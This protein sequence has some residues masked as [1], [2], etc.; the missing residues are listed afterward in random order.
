MTTYSEAVEQTI[1]AG[2]QIHQIVNGT[3][4]TEVTV[5]DGSKVPSI[6]KALLD[7]FYFKDPIAWQVGQTENVFNQ[8][9]QF[10]D[11]SWWYAPSATASNPISMG[12]TPV[13]DPLWKVYDFDAIGRLEPR[14]DEALRRSYAEAGYNVIGTFQDGF[15]YINTNDVGID[16]STGKGY[17]GPLGAVAAGTDPTSGGFVDKSSMLLS[18]DLQSGAMKLQSGKYALRDVVSIHDFGGMDD[19]IEG[20]TTG[21]NNKD[22]F[23]NAIGYLNL[24]G[25]GQLLLPRTTTG[26]Y[27]INGDDPT[28]VTSQ[29]RLVPDTG[30]SIHLIYSGGSTNSPLVN[31]NLKSASSLRIEFKNFGFTS[32]I[33]GQVDTP[34]GDTLPTLNNSEGV[35]SSP[36]QLVGSDFSLVRLSNINAVEAPSNTSTDSLMYAGAGVP[37][38]AMYE[39]M[40]GEELFSLISSSSAGTF[41]AGVVTANGYAYFAQNSGT[42]EVKLVEVTVGLNPVILGVPYSHTMNQQRDNFNNALLSVKIT[43]SRSFSVL[44]NGLVVGSYTTRSNIQ[45]ACF[46]TED[47]NDDVYLSQFSVVSGKSFGGSKPLRVLVSGDSITDNSVQHSWAK[48]LQMILGTAG[49]Q[50]AEINNFAVSGTTAAAQLALLQTVGAGYDYCLIQIGVNDIQSG[51]D[52]GDF[53]STIINMVTYAKGIGAQPIVGIP[54]S[55]YSR[56]EANANG[57]SGGQNTSNNASIHTYRAGLMRAVAAAGGLLNLEP[58]KAYG[59]MTAKWLSSVP[60]ST[61]D[62]IVVDNIHPSPWG[63]MMLAQGWARSILGH[64]VRPD[65]TKSEPYEP[66]PDSWLSSGFGL[67]SKPYIRGRELRGILSLNSTI[68]SDGAV[69]GTFPPSIRVP[70]VRMIPVTAISSGG[71]PVGVCSMYIGPDRKFYFFNLPSGATMVSLDGV[72]I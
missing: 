40:A 41:L 1:T 9:R 66:M 25:G 18:L 65:T 21:T 54:T 19:H 35:L 45:S 34:F 38:V 37:T 5:E 42:Q 30:V 64:M 59:A 39:A 67:I 70:T 51:T 31:T 58:M 47:V 3:A 13:G 71:L 50:V 2:E 10:T 17:T 4:T 69:A 53:V 23:A 28:Q 36:K 56:A 16:K 15:T 6:R 26:K 11:G 62:R 68:V 7:N 22:A 8:L 48:Y 24:Q 52:F 14:T 43:S 33:G 29:I 44:V 49:V 12:A 72:T 60:Y 63:S 27:F 61:N 32:F 20:T 55:F 46:G 57:Q